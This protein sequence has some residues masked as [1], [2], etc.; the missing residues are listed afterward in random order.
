MMYTLC[1]SA[2]I[3]AQQLLVVVR[4]ETGEADRT[5]LTSFLVRGV[6]PERL[7]LRTASEDGWVTLTEWLA[8]TR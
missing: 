4:F 8:L 5:M 6:A 1:R 7:L 2:A 3:P